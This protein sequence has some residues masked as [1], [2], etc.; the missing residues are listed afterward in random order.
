M[1]MIKSGLEFVRY[2]KV[3]YL[4]EIRSAHHKLAIHGD[5]GDMTVLSHDDFMREVVDGSIM[6]LVPDSNGTFHPV[7]EGWK[8]ERTPKAKKRHSEINRVVE[9]AEQCQ[10]RGIPFNAMDQHIKAFCI[11]QR[12]DKPPTGRTL[13]LWRAKSKGHESMVAPRWHRCGNRL[14]G[15]TP[16]LLESIKEVVAK[17]LL[18]QKDKFTLSGAWIEVQ[19]VY[20]KKWQDEHGKVSRPPCHSIRQLRRFMRM[21]PFNELRKL[22]LDNRSYRALTRRAINL[23]TAS[24]LFDAVEMDATV[25]DILICDEDGKEIGRPTLY[26]AID[27]AT[28]YPLGLYLTIQ[29]PSIVAFVECLRFMLFPKSD[30]F[31]EKYGIQNR[32]EVFG[33]PILLRVDNGSEFVSAVAEALVYEIFGDT[34]RC[35]PY[36]PEEKP[37]VERFN[38]TVRQFI[39][40][41]NGATTS[42]VTKKMREIPK[43]EPLMQL[44]ELRT[45]LYQ[46]IYDRYA[47]IAN[48]MRSLLLQKAVAPLDCVREMKDTIT[49][50]VPVSRAQFERDIAFQTETRKLAHDGISFRGWQFHSDELH[51]MYLK[52]G[53]KM[54]KFRYSELDAATI[55]VAPPDGVSGEVVANNKVPSVMGLD[56]GTADL[57]RQAISAE[58]EVL[59]ERAFDHAYRNYIQQLE[60]LKGSA[61]RAKLARV[62]DLMEATAKQMQKTM[63]QITPTDAAARQSAMPE[64]PQKPVPPPKSAQASKPTADAPAAVNPTQKTPLRGRKLG[65]ME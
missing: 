9:F 6:M 46:F 15:P 29:K 14:Q 34:A 5:D 41:L 31:D 8:Q 1:Q 24:K 12:I 26:V 48:E 38:G 45:K 28:G 37:H 56:F 64:A 10:L 57:I 44:E 22:Q 39:L 19:A 49:L 16:L 62:K 27:T 59:N 30:D 17:Q 2:G 36:K 63:A 3:C 52:Y 20:R 18:I 58:A 21:L 54:Y 43:D 4:G 47:L 33:K 61:G 65:E 11:E 13:R 40:T 25:L 32:I 23:H 53:P 50:P 51:T 7:P 55:L 42:S 35:K 60:R